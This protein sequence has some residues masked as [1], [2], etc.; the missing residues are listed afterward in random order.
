MGPDPKR[1][2]VSIVRCRDYSPEETSAA[3]T[4]AVSLL[5]L[6]DGFFSTKG[7]ILLKPNLLSRRSPERAVTT[8]PAVLESVIRAVRSR[9]PD[10]E[11][12]IGDSPGGALKR[13]ESFWEKAGFTRVSENTGVPLVSFEDMESKPF[14]ETGFRGLDS[15][16]ISKTAFDSPLIINIPKMKTHSFTYMT[17]AMKNLYGFIPGLQK[18]TI[19]KALPDHG[20]FSRFIAY[21]NTLVRPALHIVDAV[22]SMEG[23]GPSSGT[24]VHTGLIV[25]GTDS[26]AVDMVVCRLMGISPFSVTYI[27]EAVRLG[28]GPGEENRIDVRGERIEDVR[29]GSFRLPSSYMLKKLFSGV[30]IR[31]FRKFIWSRPYV[32][33]NGCTRCGKCIESCP[34]GAMTFT[35]TG[36][37]IDYDACIDCLCCH[38]LCDNDTVKLEFSFLAKR[39]FN[40]EDYGKKK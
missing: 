34:V 5:E 8:H 26:M 9:N 32:D 36:I 21:L 1:Y 16:S 12:Q 30:F 4:K 10:A 40:T 3:V 24:P 2:P 14:R 29:P 25:A 39:L 31:M 35:D 17:C 20:E 18:A 13:I 6:D 33:S 28:I 11:M 38:E 15:F 23:N 27:K 7:P 37:E 22:T 19:H